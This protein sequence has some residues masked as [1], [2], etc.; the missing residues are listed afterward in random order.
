MGKKLAIGLVAVVLLGVAG[1]FGVRFFGDRT[2]RAEVERAFEEIRRRGGVAQFA[3]ASVDPAARSIVLTGVALGGADATVK[4]ARLTATGAQPPRDNYAEAETLDLEGVEIT[5][6]GP[7]AFGGTLVYAI[8]KVMIDRYRGPVVP[9]A[10]PAGEAGPFG[11]ARFALRQFAA[12]SAAKVT[13]PS[14]TLR[15]QPAKAGAVPVELAY[16]G[17][18]A[19][20]IAAGK[21]RSLLVDKLRFSGPDEV[22]VEGSPQD[23]APTGGARQTGELSGIVA[24]RLD[25]APFLAVLTGTAPGKEPDDYQAIYGKVVTG[26]YRVKHH[27]GSTAGADSL[28]LEHVG[29]KPSA[30]ALDR[31]LELDAL[32]RK[33]PDLSVAELSALV[34]ET[35]RIIDGLAFRTFSMTGLSATSKGETVRIAAVRLDGF[36][37][38][39]LDAFE[40]EGLDGTDADKRPVKAAQ[41]VVR[42]L[43]L[44]ALADLA[45]EA[46]APTPMAALGLFKV[47]SGIEAAGVEVPYE[48]DNAAAGQ[49]LRIGALT[50]GWGSVLGEI[51]TTL[52]FEMKDVSGP[53]SAADGEPFVYLANAGITRATMSTALNIAYDPAS[54]DLQVGPLGARL[55]KAFA[56][57]LD[58]GIGNVP[59]EAFGD[60]ASAFGALGEVTARPLTLKVE[61]LGLAEL[62]FQQLAEAAGVSPD[63]IRAD[64]SA[65]VDEIAAVLAQVNPDVVDVAAAV[66]SFLATPR[67]LTLSATPRADTPLLPLF[68]NDAPFGA[69]SAFSLSATAGP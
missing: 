59:K 10:A 52:R 44:K 18:A 63:E 11:A 14:L 22:P 42:R 16:E 3:E 23:A 8:P 19:E 9:L 30:I 60:A 53:I 12:T 67:T 33:G 20:Q 32:T 48:G 1:Y 65:Q 15:Q 21:V 7:A 41:F 29:I 55:E 51:P 35:R 17:I 61:N 64:L 34:E 5:L 58:A 68:L 49:P 46:D 66:K 43:D 24:A 2:A 69:L 25:T 47:V 13:I 54:R 56:V 62:M 57:T 39:V 37:A 50:L 4:I 27:D 28:L 45:R 40:L 36:A 38:G 6:S 26:P 31:L